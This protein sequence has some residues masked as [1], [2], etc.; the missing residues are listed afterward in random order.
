MSITVITIAAAHAIPVVVG[1]VFGGKVGS[2][3]AAILMTIVAVTTGGNQYTG[4]DLI[5]IWAA[6]ILF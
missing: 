6:F 1:R 3:L 4:A 2:F 5:A